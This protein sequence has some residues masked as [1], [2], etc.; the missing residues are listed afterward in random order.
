MPKPAAA[1]AL[2][3]DF[4]TNSVR[5]LLVDIRNGRELATSVFP[6]PAG[7]AGIILDPRNPDLARQN[8]ADYL[9]GHRGRRPARPWPRPARRTAPSSPPGSS[10]SASTRPARTPIPV[11]RTACRSAF[12]KEFR[13]QPQRHGLAVE[14]PHRLRRGGR[15]HRPGR[16]RAPRIPGQV[17]RHLLLRM[18]LQQDPALPA[19]RPEGLRRR[20]RAGS[21]A[22]TGSRPPWSATRGPTGSSASRCAAGHKAMFNAA[23][24]GLPASGFPG[25][26]RSRS[27]ALCATASTTRPTRPTPPPAACRRNG[28]RRSGCPQGSRS[29]SAPSTPTWARSA[30]ASSPARSSRSS[31][32]APA[33]SASGRATSRWPTSPACAASST[34]RSCPAT[35]AWRP[36]SRPW[37]TS[38]T[39]SSTTSSRA[40][41]RTA[42]TRR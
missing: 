28:P 41:R 14:G 11:D 19:G 16:A 25:Q 32:P 9:L 35:S 30:R 17:R 6:Y 8:P 24:G 26:A 29:R 37:A 21:N 12:D 34:A 18:V 36:G 2:G 23:W 7:K 5:A 33:T 39:G 38:S 4:G 31:A 13:Q 20:L 15:N 42:R 40:A 27:W 1:Y 3:L 10:A 22:A